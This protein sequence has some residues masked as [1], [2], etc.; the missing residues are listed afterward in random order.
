ML[1]S[2][3]FD[4]DWYIK[5]IFK[6]SI[7][8]FL[9]VL[10]LETFG[11][12]PDIII[13]R[14]AD[15]I[16]YS[17]GY[18][19]PLEF[20]A[21]FFFL[22]LMFVYIKKQSINI[23]QIL[24]ILLL[25]ILIFKITDARTSF[26]LLLGIIFILSLNL[27]FDFNRIF[28]YIPKVVFILLAICLFFVPVL[29]SLF[30]DG[31]NCILSTLNN[32]VSNR[33]YLGNQALNEYGIT[34]FGNSIEWVGFGGEL[35]PSAVYSSYNFVDCWYVKN[36]LEHGIIYEIIVLVGYISVVHKLYD[37]HDFIGMIVIF[38]LLTISVLEPRLM[39]LSI[40]PFILLMA[41]FIVISN[42]NIQAFLT[43][44]D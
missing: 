40:N 3:F 24:C 11:F 43:F 20:M 31:S 9:F 17:M 38:A 42:K 6:I 25:S 14:G 41:Q 22:V 27:K 37:S 4:F 5:Y 23:Q 39:S 34:L 1:P 19:Y 29:L 15:V 8:F 21:H 10:I 36:L 33:L 13:G 18:I 2:S 7:V 28:K 12:I 35:D 44:K 32:I 16:R 26:I 30:Y